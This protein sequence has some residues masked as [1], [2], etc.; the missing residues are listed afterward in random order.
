MLKIWTRY[1]D[2]DLPLYGMARVTLSQFNLE[3]TTVTNMSGA[4]P[5]AFQWCGGLFRSD[6]SKWVL[7]S[8]TIVV[9]VPMTWLGAAM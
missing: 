3:Y 6:H 4:A 7:H 8:I 1:A 5:N 2:Y 9:S